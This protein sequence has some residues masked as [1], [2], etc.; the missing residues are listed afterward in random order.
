MDTIVATAVPAQVTHSEPTPIAPDSQKGTNYSDASSTPI[1]SKDEA[2]LTA[3]NIGDSLNFLPADQKENVVEI[4]SYIGD[5]LDSKGIAPTQE[6]YNKQLATIKEEMGID[7][8]TMAEIALNR[9]GGIVKAWK[10]MAFIS[11][12]QE[13][14][15]LFMRLAKLGSA[16]EMNEAVYKM[17]EDR[18]I[19][20]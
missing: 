7:K 9:I 11:N 6:A 2:V 5:I 14:R 19:W 1:E 3:L 18:K 16:R 20:Q 4:S 10:S 8:D 15:S 12:P 17:M 13:K